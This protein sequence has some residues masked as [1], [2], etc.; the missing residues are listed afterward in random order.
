MVK[1]MANVLSRINKNHLL[2]RLLCLAIGTFIVAFVYNKFLVP[3]HIVI[4]GVSGLA[5]LVNAVTGFSTTMFINISNV[6]LI[7]LGFFMLG[8]KKTFTQLIGSIMY[9]VMVNLTAPLASTIEFSFRSDILMIILV[10]IFY[11]IGNGLIYRAGYSTGGSDFIAQILSERCAKPMPDMSLAIQL[12]IIFAS[13]FV[14]GISKVMLSVF[15]IYMT[16]K[17]T[18]AVLLGVSTSKMVYV[19]SD[20]NDEIQD[21]IMN[22]IKTGSTEIKVSGG[23]EQR[24][25]QMLM[26]VVHNS[27]YS[28]FKNIVLDMDPEAFILAN[29]CY[30]VSG[31]QKFS[32]LPF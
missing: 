5:I 29:N 1:A 22:V 13:T 26:C 9:I 27:Q 18:N 7:I 4:G 25:R 10:S 2:S 3:N 8:R 32:V 6:L 19:I 21:F 30:A 12:V 11:G 28:R 16:N 17:I 24:K 31:G 14:L 15:I 20:K 23:I